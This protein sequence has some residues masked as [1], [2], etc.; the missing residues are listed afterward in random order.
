MRLGESVI[1]IVCGSALLAYCALAQSSG[2][3]LT[4]PVRPDPPAPI[5][6]PDARAQR[7]LLG[8]VRL[9]SLR[10]QRELPD[11]ICDQLTTRSVDD[12]GTGKHWKQRDKLQ[13][14]DVYVGGFVNHKLIAI[15]GKD[16]NKN[17]RALEGFLSETVLHSVGFL[18]AWLFG[19]QAKTQFEWLR[20]EMLD[21]RR[22]E[23]FSV[24]LAAADSQFTISAQRDM[25]VAGIDGEIYVDAI[26]AVV[27]KFEIHMD[28][29]ANS[30]LQEGKLDIDYGQVSI[31]SRSFLLPVRFEVQ[32]RYGASLV[33][34]ETQVVRYQKY[35]AVSTI[36]FDEPPPDAPEA[37]NGP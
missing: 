26:S 20:E 22:M 31:S 6:P 17:Y 4:P 14:Q 32:A 27:R 10:Y 18:P 2:I 16:A 5:G 21:G 23:V 33:K 24:H 1:G 36:H 28:L 12:G 7:V 25:F 37:A 11:F 9:E 34:N 13:V 30:V 3:Q 35:G 8:R 29:P 15:N 19:P